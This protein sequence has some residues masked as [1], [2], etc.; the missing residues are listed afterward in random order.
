MRNQFVFGIDAHDRNTTH[1]SA[2]SGIFNIF[3]LSVSVQVLSSAFLSTKIFK[4]MVLS[5]IEMRHRYMYTYL[6]TDIKIISR[7]Y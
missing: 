7:E 5:N 3:L 1:D 6:Y 2:S 4:E